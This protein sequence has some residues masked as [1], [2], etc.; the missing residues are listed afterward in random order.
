MT[1]DSIAGP[2]RHLFQDLF[3]L[4]LGVCCR[5]ASWRLKDRQM[6]PSSGLARGSLA[7]AFGAAFDFGMGLAG[8]G[9]A[10]G[11]HDF[12]TAH[13]SV[14]LRPPGLSI[15]ALSVVAQGWADAEMAPAILTS[16]AALATSTSSAAALPAPL[17][18]TSSAPSSKTASRTTQLTSEPNDAKRRNQSPEPSALCLAPGLIPQRGIPQSGESGQTLRKPKKHLRRHCSSVC[19]KSKTH[20]SAAAVVSHLYRP[21]VQPEGLSVNR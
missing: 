9:L 11:V 17:T 20:R 12:S 1:H 13:L 4:A 2:S 15:R 3:Q 10:P 21:F 14:P 8:P 5:P 19:H 6:S 16:S 7:V 18:S